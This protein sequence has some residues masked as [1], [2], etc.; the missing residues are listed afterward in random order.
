MTF[1]VITARKREERAK[2]E[3]R[4]N[5]WRKSEA[6]GGAHQSHEGSR[7]TGGFLV[8]CRVGSTVGWLVELWEQKHALKSD[9]RHLEQTGGCWF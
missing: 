8:F 1:P 5:K 4:C 6:P 3:V 9:S 7:R 2:R